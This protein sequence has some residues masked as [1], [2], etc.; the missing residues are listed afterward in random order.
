MWLEELSGL[1]TASPQAWSLRLMCLLASVMLLL[2]LLIVVERGT[3][4]VQLLQRPRHRAGG[5]R[6]RPVRTGWHSL[7]NEGRGGAGYSFELEPSSARTALIS[8]LGHLVLGVGLGNLAR[9]CGTR[10]LRLGRLFTFRPRLFFRLVA[11]L[12][13]PHG[14]TG[15]VA[16][17]L[18]P[19]IIL[20]LRAAGGDGFRRP[21]HCR[22]EI[23]GLGVGRAERAEDVSLRVVC[24]LA[25]LF[26]ELDRACRRGAC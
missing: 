12:Q 25:R 10:L 4:V 21:F 2:T 13:F 20:L 17:H 23:A 22:S 1:D 14:F 6:G 5:Q 7:R 9:F 15:L 18:F 16:F 19:E 26:G 24:Q 3:A 8:R 11:G